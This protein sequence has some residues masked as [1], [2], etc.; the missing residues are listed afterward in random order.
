MRRILR[1]FS[2]F[3]FQIAFS[4]K[5][6]IYKSL[7]WE[8]KFFSCTLI[9]RSI[10]NTRRDVIEFLIISLMC[11]TRFLFRHHCYYSCLLVFF[12]KKKSN[13]KAR[14]WTA[15]SLSTEMKNVLLFYMREFIITSYYQNHSRSRFFPSIYWTLP[16]SHSDGVNQNKKTYFTM[17]YSFY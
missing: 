17:E 11:C 10:S 8:I 5:A 16:I 14:E 1:L 12:W 3:A 2:I 13:E 6:C 9:Y 15:S 4:L 7:Y